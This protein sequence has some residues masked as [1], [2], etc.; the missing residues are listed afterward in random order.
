[1]TT[2][3][4]A[5]NAKRMALAIEISDLTCGCLEDDIAKILGRKCPCGNKCM[6]TRNKHIENPEKQDERCSC[7]PHCGLCIGACSPGQ[8]M[9]IMQ[10]SHVIKTEKTHLGKHCPRWCEL[11]YR[12]LPS[13]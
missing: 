6:G 4:K 2:P 11:A 13:A 8:E 9:D 1:M 10:G 3:R 12:R 5:A 7:E